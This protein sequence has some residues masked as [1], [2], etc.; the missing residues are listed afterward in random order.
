MTG[1][2]GGGQK[3]LS[4]IIEKNW[5]AEEPEVIIYYCQVDGCAGHVGGEG[6]PGGPGGAGADG[7]DAEQ[8]DALLGSAD[9]VLIGCDQNTFQPHWGVLEHTGERVEVGPDGRIIRSA[10]G[11]PGGMGGA[12]GD[13]GTSG[14]SEAH[15]QFTTTNNLWRYTPQGDEYISM[16]GDTN[17]FIS[18][19]YF[20]QHAHTGDGGSGGTGGNGGQGGTGGTGGTGG[21]GGSGGNS[22]VSGE[23]EDA[24]G[25]AGGSGGGGGN[26][27]T[28][29]DANG[30]NGGDGGDGGKSG[31]ANTTINYET[32]YKSIYYIE[33]TDCYFY[34]TND[35]IEPYLLALY[36]M[37]LL[38]R[39]KGILTTS[40][41][42]GDLPPLFE[43]QIMPVATAGL[44][45]SSFAA[46]RPY[47]SEDATAQFLGLGLGAP[48][49]V[50]PVDADTAPY[51][52]DIGSH[53]YLGRNFEV[54][55][56]GRITTISRAT[57]FQSNTGYFKTES[58][59]RMDVY[60]YIYDMVSAGEKKLTSLEA[61]IV[62]Y[63]YGMQYEGIASDADVEVIKYLVAKGILNYD[64]SNELDNLYSAICW[65]DF[66]PILYRVANKAARLDFSKIQ[67]TDSEQSWMSLSCPAVMWA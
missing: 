16:F 60:R 10:D 21:N 58:L 50:K 33:G 8:H 4:Y 22:A 56:D 18:E 7:A 17:I 43:T 15:V 24:V 65:Q 1:N 38:E 45:G 25:V 42:G 6:T 51:D 14:E 27:G 35:G 59:T 40:A 66:L 48:V 19:N 55:Q 49:V 39:D 30:G 9:D 52:T 29:G 57:L 54:T 5:E 64:G 12:G 46:D 26:G 62:N 47:W 31:N 63:K 37:G 13:G 53:R 67:L 23:G 41:N 11:Q 28:G 61:D 34:R 32:D 36:S 2:A 44:P 3:P 20:E